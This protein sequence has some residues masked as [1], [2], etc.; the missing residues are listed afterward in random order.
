MRSGSS[1]RFFLGL[2]AGLGLLQAGCTPGMGDRPSNLALSSEDSKKL[3]NDRLERRNHVRTAIADLRHTLRP[4][5]KVM[6]DISKHV[7]AQVAV[8]GQGVRKLP[9]GIRLVD[10]ML[11]K[12]FTGAVRYNPDGSWY[13]AEELK[14]DAGIRLGTCESARVEL[15][16]RRVEDADQLGLFLIQCGSPDKILL[17]DVQ[18]QDKKVSAALHLEN[19]KDL[20]LSVN[21]VSG[22]CSIVVGLE[23]GTVDC[24]PFDVRLHDTRINVYLLSVS[25]TQTGFSGKAGAHVFGMKDGAETEQGTFSFRF[26]SAP[27][28]SDLIEEAL[29]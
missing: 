16:G 17:A 23:G 18:L 5:T 8:D 21:A 4:V 1:Y 2:I 9:D 27:T 24:L 26:S 25:V 13:V 19:L 20:Q 22:T 29:E 28:G 6:D 15:D 3:E 7:D 11:E 10:R 12:A 14:L